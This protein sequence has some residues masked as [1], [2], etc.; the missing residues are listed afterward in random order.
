MAKKRFCPINKKFPTFGVLLLVFGLIWL[1][2]DLNMIQVDVPWIP[3]VI[4]IIALG[5]IYN[6]LCE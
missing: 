4:V 5:M 6:R 1:L 3:I 2:N